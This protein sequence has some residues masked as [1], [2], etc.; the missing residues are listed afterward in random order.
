MVGYRNLM[1]A[2]GGE[3]S[4][5]KK[6]GAYSME[7]KGGGGTRGLCLENQAGLSASSEN[8]DTGFQRA[9]FLRAFWYERGE[10]ERESKKTTTEEKRSHEEGCVQKNSRNSAPG[11]ANG[12][13][14]RD[15]DSFRKWGENIPEVKKPRQE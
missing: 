4:E 5:K 7:Q 1:D 15:A 3:A 11:N 10:K 12:S 9:L 6:K 2:G 14:N 13:G 8:T